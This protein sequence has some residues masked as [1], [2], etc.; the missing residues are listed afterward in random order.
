VQLRF[1]RRHWNKLAKT[2]PL[3]AVLTSP[4]KKGNRWTIEEFFADGR[5]TVTTAINDI[6]SQCVE[7]RQG[8]ALDFGCGV[9][10]LTQA[11]AQ[12]F[13][14]VTGVDI[15]EEM[16]V[17]ARRHNEH[18]ERVTYVHN[19]HSDLHLFGTD[20]FDLV[21]SLI[22]LQ[23]MEPLYAKTYIAEF[24]RITAAGGLILF[25]VPSQ[26]IAEKPENTLL[27]FWPP[28]FFKRLRRRIKRRLNVWLA[29][30]PLME[31][32][33]IPAEEV[34]AILKQNGAEVL[35]VTRYHAAGELES[36]AYLARKL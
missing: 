35:Q 6:K 18:G 17:H 12:H 30:D 29:S 9:G 16:L 36:W 19:P 7:L 8:S 26:R 31:M 14:R 15:S 21:Y 20:Q 27:T 34:R 4:E 10:R 28:T 5:A 3:W 2:D 11:L 24:V 33:A 13:E 25:Q 1:T 23:H 22:T 32:H